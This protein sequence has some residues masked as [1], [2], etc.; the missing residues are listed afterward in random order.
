M[1]KITVTGGD[2]FHLAAQYLRDATQWNR[3]A[4]LNGMIDPEVSGLVT[5]LIPD[6]DPSAGGG[7]AQ[8]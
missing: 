2:L 5:L 7:I 4:Q 3:I 6:V 8:Q 1:R